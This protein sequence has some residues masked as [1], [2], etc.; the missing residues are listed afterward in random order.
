MNSSNFIAK[1]V[2]ALFLIQIVAAIA[3]NILIMS[4]TSPDDFLSS[5]AANDS[6]LGL[7][8]LLMFTCY[9]SVIAI[10]IIIYPV[11]KRYNT[12]IALSYIATRLVE[13]IVQVFG[14]VA[15]IALIPL[16]HAY[17]QMPEAEQLSTLVFAKSS[18]YLNW[19]AY[20]VSMIFLGYGSLF[21]CYILYKH[22][23]V[24]K[25]L[26]ALGL[27]GYFVLATSSVLYI[28]GMD[29]GVFVAIPILIFEVALGLCLVIKGFKVPVNS[30]IDKN[31]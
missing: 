13:T 20:H 12:S 26:A 29:M 25:V 4:V 6:K 30:G 11:L 17:L 10:G 22:A 31:E 7:A 3:G 2:G 28:V 14:I 27:F 16:S 23:L 8:A 15:V 9:V 24:P 18:I 1:A 21:F 19:Y 5:I